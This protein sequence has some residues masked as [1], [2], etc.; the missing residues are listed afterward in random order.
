[1]SNTKAT[2]EVTHNI[3][4]EFSFNLESHGVS[5]YFEGMND[6]DNADGVEDVPLMNIIREGF[7]LGHTL[8]TELASLRKLRKDIKQFMEQ[9]QREAME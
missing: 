3:E 9:L 5:V 1:M 4:V 2:I 6:Q 7:G 8:Q